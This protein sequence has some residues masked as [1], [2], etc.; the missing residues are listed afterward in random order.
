MP[1]I[2]Y[3]L[4]IVI[5]TRNEQE[6]VEE[7]INS[8]GGLAV[9]HEILVVDDDS[10]DDTEAIATRL[11]VRV[12]KHALNE[13]FSAQR[14]WALTHAKGEW[15]FF[16]D[17]DERCTKPLIG[18]INQFLSDPDNNIGVYL[19]RHDYFCGRL[20]RF[21]EIGHIRLMRLAQKDYG[22]WEGKVDEVWK[23][24]GETICF[25]NPLLHYSHPDLSQF[26]E[27]INTRSTLNAR[28][29]YDSGIHNQWFDWVKPEAK[30]IQNYIFRV[31]F[32]DGLA[33]FVFAVLM[34]FHSFLVRGK[35]YLLWK[36]NET[37]S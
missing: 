11:G 16:L 35:L 31:G 29:L 5:L 22:L 33:G 19:K 8:L 18:E 21:G 36:R 6:N 37:N 24:R 4:S 20:L 30:F 3:H 12:I 32:L 7:C 28:Q 25:N 13:D 10:T 2:N 17:A 34:S 15:V 1:K 23:G 27:N 26:L 14:N 9:E